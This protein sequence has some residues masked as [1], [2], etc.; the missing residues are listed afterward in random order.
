MRQVTK[1][2]S[3]APDI[4]EKLVVENPLALPSRAKAKD[5]IIRTFV[6]RFVKDDPIFC[7]SWG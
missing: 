6:P 2:W 3:D 1:L 5:V 7:V 4:A